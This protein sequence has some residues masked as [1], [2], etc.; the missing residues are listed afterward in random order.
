MAVRALDNSE[1]DLGERRL[2]ETSDL[3]V[4][5]RRRRKRRQ[6]RQA[7][8]DA[9]K[10]SAGRVGLRL[11]GLM[12]AVLLIY[13]GLILW[14]LQAATRSIGPYALGMTQADVR[15]QF[16]EPQG[17]SHGTS[18]WNYVNA[19]SRIRLGF[20]ADGRLAL[21][22]CFQEV[23]Y[24]GPCPQKL[25]VGIGSTE[26]D[27]VRLLGPPDAARYDREDKIVRYRGIG[28][29]ARFQ[30]LRVVEIEHSSASGAAGMARVALWRML[31]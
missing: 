23:I 4:G 25:G 16:G 31:P 2:A 29:K 18:V 17:V 19:G 10:G 28:L 27:V 22:T 12:C 5:R 13:C 11:F 3:D 24:E 15:Y 8:K 1:A 20:G 9:G 26:S 6:E 7:L 21:V 14:Q 30:K